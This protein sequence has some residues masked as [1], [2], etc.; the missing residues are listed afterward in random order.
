MWWGVWTLNRLLKHHGGWMT[1]FAVCVVLRRTLVSPILLPIR[2]SRQAS[3]F[4]IVGAQKA[5][6]MRHVR[7]PRRLALASNSHGFGGP[8]F[9]GRLQSG[10]NKD[11]ADG[12]DAFLGPELFFSPRTL[13]EVNSHYLPR[14]KHDTAAHQLM[15]P[16][17]RGDGHPQ[18]PNWEECRHPL[19]GRI[20][21]PTRKRPQP[22]PLHKTR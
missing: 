20:S 13:K 6:C 14:H 4:P 11:A 18:P 8:S 7:T 5:A 16:T 22:W 9:D 3:F 19:L 10:L 1:A 21:G 15:V 17:P 12:G 2:A